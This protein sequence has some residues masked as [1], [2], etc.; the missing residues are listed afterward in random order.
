MSLPSAECKTPP[1]CQKVKFKFTGAASLSAVGRR[2]E[3]V[4][5][6][7]GVEEEMVVGGWVVNS[8]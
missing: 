8:L 1:L 7:R 2:A 4:C 3:S 6:H 5:G